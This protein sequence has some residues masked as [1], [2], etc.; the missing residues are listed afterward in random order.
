MEL[1]NE[2][3]LLTKL[4]ISRSTCSSE[5]K[6][7]SILYGWRKGFVKYPTQVKIFKLISQK[8]KEA[9]GEINLVF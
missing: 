8:E 4:E 2:S 9:V 1:T 6:R 5:R 7:R 3:S